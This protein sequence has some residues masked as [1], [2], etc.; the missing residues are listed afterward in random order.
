MRCAPLFF[1]GRQSQA[2]GCPA[3]R[4]PRGRASGVASPRTAARKGPGGDRPPAGLSNRAH[5][6]WRPTPRRSAPS[7]ARA[8][9]RGAGRRRRQNLRTS[10]N[11]SRSS[12]RRRNPSRVRRKELEH[13]DPDPPVVADPLAEHM[14]SAVLKRENCNHANANPDRKRRIGHLGKYLDQT[15][16]LTTRNKQEC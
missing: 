13:Q 15:W 10:R 16:L 9:S 11:L 4:S 7:S 2:L 8:P 6:S 3:R 5:P 12:A 14:P 1:Y